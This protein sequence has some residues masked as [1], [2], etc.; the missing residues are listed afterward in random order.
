[1]ISRFTLFERLLRRLHLLPS[2]VMDAF[3]GVLFGRLLAIAVRRGVIEAAAARPCPLRD[4]AGQA[5]L[6]ER[7]ARLVCEALTVT[8]YLRRTPQGYFATPD[9]RKWLLP[10]SPHS[11][12]Y[13]VQYFETL[14]ARWQDLEYALIHGA[15]VRPYSAAFADADWELYVLAMR[16]LARMLLP[17]VMRLLH[18][19]EGEGKLLDVG[20]SHGLYTIEACRRAPGL[21]ATIMDFPQA[22][23]HARPLVAAAGLAG[24]CTLLEGDF[25]THPFPPG[26]DVVLLFNVIH[27]FDREGNYRLVQ[28]SLDAL[29]PGGRIY[30]LDQFDAAGRGSQLARFMP[31]MVGLNLLSEIGGTVYSVE[32]VRKW[33]DGRA[34]LTKHRTALPGVTLVEL[35]RP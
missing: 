4:I 3:G 22:L 19:P 14:H 32:D 26:Q 6:D 7:A 35:T 9:A 11:L 15:P 21:S 27:G 1:M 5:G 31:L 29:C 25:T 30:I 17:S 20:G 8:G 12:F 10:D 23:A 2:P 18:L 28:R 33:S 24:R 34:S 16:D 13:L